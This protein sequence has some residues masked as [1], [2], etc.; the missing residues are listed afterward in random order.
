VI[1]ERIMEIEGWRHG[2]AEHEAPVRWDDANI[3]LSGVGD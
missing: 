2:I 1:A 3:G